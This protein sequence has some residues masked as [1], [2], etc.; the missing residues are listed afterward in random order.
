M[1]DDPREVLKAAGV[2]C[3]EVEKVGM[4]R[5]WYDP[6]ASHQHAL[7]IIEIDDAA[8]LALARLV[9]KYKWQREIQVVGALDYNGA[10]ARLDQY[11]EEHLAEQ[12]ADYARPDA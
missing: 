9:A 8:I 6:K 11:W 2:E 10:V 3:A 7:N 12:E 4:S 1:P 5:G